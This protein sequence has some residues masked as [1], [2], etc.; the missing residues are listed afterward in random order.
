MAAGDALFVDVVHT[1]GVPF[2]PT[3]GL[4]VMHAVGKR[5]DG[6]GPGGERLTGNNCTR[7][8]KIKVKI[9]KKISIKS[10]KKNCILLVD[11]FL[12]QFFTPIRSQGML[13]SSDSSPALRLE[14]EKLLKVR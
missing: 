13:K 2:I 14:K 4:G 6:P 9:R 5:Q 3:L 7:A 11:F 12:C 8:K 1:N 10:S